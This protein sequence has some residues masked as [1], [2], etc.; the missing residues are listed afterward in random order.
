MEDTL[1]ALGRAGFV[2]PTS[3]GSPEEYTFKHALTRDVAYESLLPDT[4]RELH[5]TLVDVLEKV[6]ATRLLEKA[7][8]LGEHAFRGGLWS[9]AVTYL[10]QA[11]RKALAQSA[12]REVVAALERALDAL[13][14]L[15][16]TR[17]TLEQGIDLRVGLRSALYPLGEIRRVLDHLTAAETI[18]E[19]L[20]DQAGLR[21]FNSLEAAELS[22]ASSL[23]T[24]LSRSDRSARTTRT[25]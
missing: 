23:S 24:W 10:Q 3:N 9:K 5:A 16:E 13:A 12:F 11:A 14:H 15:P 18:G 1:T 20:A 7:E 19:R 2:I 8:H 6:H 17:D 22:S 4:R 21:A 25:S